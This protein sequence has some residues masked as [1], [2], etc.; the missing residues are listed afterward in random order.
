M[1]IVPQKTSIKNWH[2]CDRPREKLLNKGKSALS[3]AELIAILIGSG[4]HN[5]SAVE[6]SKRILNTCDNSLIELSRMTLSELKKFK[7]I[8]EAKAI[9]IAAALEL[10]RRRRGAEVLEKKLIRTS[11]DAFEIIQML[12]GVSLYEQFVVLFLSNSQHLI[13]TQVVSEGGVTGTVVDPRK[14]FRLALECN[15]VAMVLGHNHPSGSTNPSQKDID[16][17]KK[18]LIAG[19]AI[20]IIVVDHVII[21]TENYYSFADDGAL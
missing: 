17:T 18:M 20:E 12:I 11:R 21:G 1:E 13:E 6:L 5:E 8:G 16:L 2:E 3:D 10:G 15:A 19:K 4:S 14:I 9:T 7:G